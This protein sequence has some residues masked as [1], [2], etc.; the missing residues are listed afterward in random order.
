MRFVWR[1]SF[2]L[3][4]VLWIVLFA[5]EKSTDSEKKSWDVTQP[6]GVVDTVTFTVEE[7]TWMNLDVSPDGKEI[8]FDLLGDIY[9]MPIE[10]GEARLLQGGL[11]YDVQPRFSP[12]GKYISFTSDRS[13]GDNIWIMNRDGSNPRQ[14]TNETFRLLNNA[15]WTPDGQYLIA[16]KHF[17]SRRSLGAGEM[18]MYHFTGGKGLRLTKRKNDQQDAGEPWV[19]PDGRYLY[20]SEDMSP[21]GVFRY[22]KDPNGQIYVIRRLNLETGEIENYIQ[23]QGG[24]VRPQISR[25]GRYL[26]FVRRV[27]A[28][29]VLYLHDFRTG[30]QWP[31]FDRL[32]KD[33]QETWAIFGVYPNYNWTP[34]NRHI[35]IWAQGKI[36]KIDVQTREAR[37]IPFKAQVTQYISRALHFP[38]QAHPDRFQVKM[39]R[40]ARTS[41]DGKWLVF[42]AVGYLWKKRLPDGIPRR[43]T[44]D[45]HFE[46]EPAFS[47]DGKWVVYTTWDDEEKGAI[48][49]IPLKGGWSRKLTREKGYYHSPTF[50]PD[51]SKIVFR[52]GKGNRVLGYAYGVQPGLYWMSSDGGEMHF[53]RKEGTRPVFSGDGKRIYFM[54][55]QEGKK[56]LKSVRLDGGDERTHFV[57]KYA[58]TILPS[59]DEKWVAWQELFNIYIAPF[60]KTGGVIEL[61]AETK[62]IPIQKVTRDAGNYLHWSND[63]QKL[64]WVIGPQYFTRDLKETFAFVEGAPQ[65]IPPPDSVGIDIGLYLDADKPEGTMALVGARIITMRGDEVIENGTVLVKEN[66]ILEIGPVDQVSIPPKTF[67]VDVKGKTIIPGL[68]DV[69]AHLPNS[70]NGISPQQSWPYFANLAYGVTTAHDPSANTEMVFSQAEM[71]KAGIM[72]GPRIYST[73]TIL[74]GAEGDFK[75]VVNSLEDA[76]SHLRRMKAV[77]AFTV[78]SYNQPRRNQRQQ[79]IQAARELGIMVLPEGGSTFFHNMNMILDG[80]TGIEHSI[81]IAPVYQDV[82]RL[83]AAS[84]TAYTPTLIVAYGGLWGEN[85]WYMVT[86]VWEKKRLLTYVPRSLVDARSRRRMKAPEDEFG[87]IQNARA[88]KAL[89]D[90]GVRVNLGAHG[91]LQGLGVHWE[92]WMLVQGGMSPLEALRC[93]TLNG[94]HYLGLEAD[95]GSLEPG[96]LADLVVLDR[97][98][99]ENIQHTEQV[100]Y[101]MKNGRLYD[102]ATMNELGRKPRKRKPFYWEMDP[103]SDRWVWDEILESPVCGC[104]QGIF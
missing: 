95:L 49:K 22:N 13:G 45:E 51:G 65:E 14:V 37:I 52:K 61:S 25:N 63:S 5:G 44:K 97:N 101:V 24:A 34:D 50:S 17:T 29:S 20:W 68:I 84:Q 80:H 85:Y 98:P 77:G 21:G 15:V 26:A 43:L 71:V 89:A 18:W 3:F 78:K 55:R 94:A 58:V 74:Y 27:R 104:Q 56:A 91:Q 66:R 40:H 96:K 79:I 4:F 90:A 82:I 64:H 69:H 100:V 7:G 67:V 36:W 8:V 28:K 72:V 32:S 1:Q 19:S 88:A 33:Q 57:S 39:I 70:G 53:I 10:G 35:I 31:I 9:I 62:A 6:R 99:L 42:N 76:R 2:G 75:A 83:W 11:S 87:H 93:A 12:D 54:S 46:F 60:P 48:Y 86:N 103:G 73:G 102:A 38:Q 30:E 59:P 16:R 23:I 41:P 92:L 47:P 81:P